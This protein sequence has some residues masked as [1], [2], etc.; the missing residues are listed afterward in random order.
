MAK[1]AKGTKLSFSGGEYSD[2]WDYGPFEVMVDFDQAEVCAVYIAQHAPRD[3]WDKPDEHGF[4]AWLTLNGY[5]R[6]VPNSYNWYLGGYDFE[7][8]IA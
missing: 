4:V 5:I 8:V 2:K 6:D 1:I 7:P 3:E